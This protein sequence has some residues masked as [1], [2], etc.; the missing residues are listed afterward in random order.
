MSDEKLHINELLT[1]AC[2]F[3]NNSTLE[4]IKTVIE[5]FYTEEEI[6]ESKTFLWNVA[7]KDLEPY[8]PRKSTAKR[9]CSSANIDDI[10]KALNKLDNDD[11]L[12]KFVAFNL[13]RVPN[14]QPEELNL[15]Y[16]VE[17]L[18]KVENKLKQHDDTLSSHAVTLM[19]LKD[20]KPSDSC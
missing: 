9:S 6:V 1:Y 5:N 16:I 17:R 3:M 15:L 10:L 2:H 13:S 8:Q 4:N 19:Q 11:K 14:R 12:P 7:D 20:K 18:T